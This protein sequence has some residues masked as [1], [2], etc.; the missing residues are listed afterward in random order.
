MKFLLE[1]I[2]IGDLRRPCPPPPKPNHYAFCQRSPALCPSADDDGGEERVYILRVQFMY[3]R[4]FQGPPLE[5]KFE[6][7]E[8][9]KSH[10]PHFWA[11]LFFM[12]LFLINQFSLFFLLFFKTFRY[13]FILESLIFL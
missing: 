4:G 2:L 10:L 5:W 1:I 7:K 8:C 11:Y 6:N 9:R 12:F 3:L 13:F